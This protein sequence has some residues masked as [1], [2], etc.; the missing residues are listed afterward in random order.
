MVGKIVGLIKQEI[1]RGS[2]IDLE[3]RSAR[4]GGILACPLHID[5]GSSTRII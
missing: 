1:R 4:A 2:I 5:R 3:G